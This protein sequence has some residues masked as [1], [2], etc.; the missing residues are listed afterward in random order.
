MGKAMKTS[1]TI[2]IFLAVSG[3]TSAYTSE[4]IAAESKKANDFF[5]KCWDETLSRH[6]VDE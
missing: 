5:E 6:L 3:I 1:L 4:E 2:A